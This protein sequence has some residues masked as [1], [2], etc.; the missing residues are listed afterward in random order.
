MHIAEGILTLPVLLSGAVLSSGG[1]ALGLRQLSPDRVPLTALLASVFFVASLV[2][3]PA[4]VSS[5]HLVLNGLCGILLGW[6]AFPAILV[7]LFLQAILF[8]FGGLTTLGVNTLLM[9]TPAV[10]CHY[11]IGRNLLNHSIEQIFW[12]GCV[13]GALAIV[14][15][16]V[17][18]STILFAS[19]GEAFLAVIAVISLSYIPVMLVEAIT[20]GF[21]VAFL[22]RVQPELLQMADYLQQELPSK[23]EEWR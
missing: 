17:L 6:T 3:L 2:H 14:L 12:R 23:V 18:L 15:G 16:V 5:V 9:A 1:V 21:V 4:G 10:L 13:A 20:T 19:G 22:A 8:G 11:L 7:A